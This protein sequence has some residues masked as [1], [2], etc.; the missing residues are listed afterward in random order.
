MNTRIA[1]SI[2]IFLIAQFTFAQN[3][4][5]QV[6]QTWSKA[7]KLKKTKLHHGL[8]EGNGGFYS[9][10]R[11]GFRK[12][13][14]EEEIALYSISFYDANLNLVKKKATKIKFTKDP[15]YP[16][17]KVI[18]FEYVNDKLLLF[19]YHYVKKEKKKYIYAYSLD[20]NTLEE[21]EPRKKIMEIETKGLRKFHTKVGATMS[22]DRSKFLFWQVN[23]LKKGRIE[24]NVC[25]VDQNLNLHWE[26]M[27]ANKDLF[28]GSPKRVIPIN[29][30]L[31]N[32]YGT[33]YDYHVGKMDLL[34]LNKEK[35]EQVYFSTSG[36]E[37]E[38]LHLKLGKDQLPIFVGFYHEKM[39]DFF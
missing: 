15:N 28:P 36:K 27:L 31:V 8:V 7:L 37:T 34:T 9:L 3:G 29:K 23:P 16:K 32:N 35:W 20:P 5:F 21:I 30:V 14:M 19:H 25:V 24:L 17:S 6:E 2:L 33:G 12:N 39:T 22:P 11:E 1:L 4:E 38:R 26:Y 18:L 13:I 10:L